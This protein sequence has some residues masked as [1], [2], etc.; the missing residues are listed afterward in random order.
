MFPISSTMSI[1]GNTSSEKNR[2]IDLLGIK[3]PI[4][5]SDKFEQNLVRHLLRNNPNRYNQF[6]RFVV[7]DHKRKQIWHDLKKR[8]RLHIT[9][10]YSKRAELTDSQEIV[11]EQFI[12]QT[13]RKR[14]SDCIIAF[15]KL[16]LKTP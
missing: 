10:H 7:K 15:D 8:E 12:D 5:Y 16:N 1:T 13:L 2:S 6:H 3:T 9:R 14:D 11:A 4:I